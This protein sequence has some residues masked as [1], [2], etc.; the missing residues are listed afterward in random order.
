MIKGVEV[1]RR[2]VEKLLGHDM[3]LLSLSFIHRFASISIGNRKTTG[4]S[5]RLE[6]KRVIGNDELKLG[7]YSTSVPLRPVL[8]T[9]RDNLN[10][11]DRAVRLS[12]SAC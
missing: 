3:S 5:N 7:A 8:E 1:S 10:T 9:G 11:A 4:R 6:E 12:G 2:I